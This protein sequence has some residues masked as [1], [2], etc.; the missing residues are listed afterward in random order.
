M[1][2]SSLHHLVCD[3]EPGEVVHLP[4]GTHLEVKFRR[5]L[6]PSRWQIEDRPGHLVPLQEADHGFRF[7]VFSASETS[8]HP[9]RLVRSRPDRPGPGEVRDLTVLVS[10]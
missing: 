2:V 7:L 10:G 8:H 9:L 6:G 3:P 4:A 5:G 1:T